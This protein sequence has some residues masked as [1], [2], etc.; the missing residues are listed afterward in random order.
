MLMGGCGARLSHDE[1]L[2]DTTGSSGGSTSAVNF[3]GS[4]E[5]TTTGLEELDTSSG[6]GSSGTSSP[7]CGNGSIDE[8]E[9]CDDGEL[10]GV[11]GQCADDCSGPGPYCGDAIVNG[12]EVCDDGVNDWSYEG[13]G[14]GCLSP[15]PYCGDGIAQATEAC[16]DGNATDGD[17]CNTDCYPAATEIWS[18]S[19]V[20][21]PWTGYPVELI[22]GEGAEVVVAGQGP[23]IAEFSAEDG[24]TSWAQYVLEDTVLA[25]VSAYDMVPDGDGFLLGGFGQLLDGDYAGWTAYIDNTI[26]L[27]QT[28]LSDVMSSVFG[29]AV[30]D[31]GDR[32]IVGSNGVLGGASFLVLPGVPAIPE[33]YAGAQMTHV[34]FDAAGGVVVGVGSVPAA[35]GNYTAALRSYDALG[36]VQWETLLLVDDAFGSTTIR[37]IL[38]TDDGGFVVVGTRRATAIVCFGFWCDSEAAGSAWGFLGR[39]DANGG[40][41]WEIYDP[42]HALYD[43]ALDPLTQDLVVVGSFE[44]VALQRV[45]WLAKYTLDGDLRWEVDDDRLGYVDTDLTRVAIGAEGDIFVAGTSF[46]ARLTP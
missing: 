8:D 46:L 35:G 21:S 3:E 32:A 27:P 41:L 43:V 36:Q 10:N 17:G 29:V 12:D 6:S 4:S 13:C 19:F 44:G 26:P 14:E 1:L 33:S 24:S 7:A 38:V 22:A 5:S 18:Q 39:Y 42:V 45:N 2:E 20:D 28:E 31:V 23:V 9:A 37:E 11:Y 16:D 40:S 30:S 34:A 25:S 15:G